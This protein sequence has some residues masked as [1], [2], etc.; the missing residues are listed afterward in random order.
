MRRIMAVALAGLL[1]SGCGE[2]KVDG[3]SEEALKSSLAEVAKPLSD[4]E[5]KQFM[6]DVMLLSLGSMDLKGVFTGEK[7]PADV[8]ANMLAT[9][10]GKTAA[11]ISTEASRL[12]AERETRERTQAIAEISELT[13]KKSKAESAKLELVKFEVSKSR[14]YL[15][16]G[17]YDYRANPYIEISVRNG[18]NQAVSRAYFKGTIASPGR[19]IPWLVEDFNYSISGGL[20]PGETQSW[21]LAPNSFGK[22]GEVDAPDGAVFTVEVV[23]LDGADGKAL[24]GS[25]E[26]TKRDSDRLDLLRKQYQN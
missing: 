24:F 9:L 18:T 1:L 8:T 13:D 12:R 26:F 23:S 25:G 5:R 15:K 16:K 10:D 2:P 7:K 11:Q 22:W 19:S 4:A 21:T 3:R 14:F 17:K 6:S 20:E